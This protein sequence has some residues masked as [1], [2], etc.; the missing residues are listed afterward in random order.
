MP[1]RALSCQ[2][3]LDLL[4]ELT[5]MKDLL[6]ILVKCKEKLDAKEITLESMMGV[7]GLLQNK[8]REEYIL[9][10]IK[11]LA[12]DLVTPLVRQQHRFERNTNLFVFFIPNFFENIV[13]RPPLADVFIATF[14]IIFLS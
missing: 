8:F 13:W 1:C 2:N 3:C 11:Y 7:F 5:T 14:L 9:Y 4:T 12:L 10:K 6:D